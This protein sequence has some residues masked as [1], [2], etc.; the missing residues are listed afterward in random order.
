MHGLTILSL[1]LL[2]GVILPSQLTLATQS[3]SALQYVLSE[4]QDKRAVNTIGCIMNKLDIDLELLMLPWARAKRELNEGKVDGVFLTSP[5]EI[6]GGIS[7]SPIL[8]EKW[9]LFQR[10]SVVEQGAR[11][12]LGVVRG[13]DIENWLLDN[14]LLPLIK[15]R[16]TAQLVQQFEAGRID[17]FVADDSQVRF[18]FKAPVN[19]REFLRYVPK[20]LT[21]SAAVVQRFP[22]LQEQFNATIDKCDPQVRALSDSERQ[23]VKD[24][25]TEHLLHRFNGTLQPMIEQWLLRVKEASPD[26]L[27]KLEAQWQAELQGTSGAL[28]KHIVHN[29]LAQKLRDIQQELSVIAELML[30][31]Q[32]GELIAASVVTSDYWQGDELKVQALSYQP[33]YISSLH[34]DASTRQFLTH[35]SLALSANGQR[36]ILIV[37]V[38]LEQLLKQGSLRL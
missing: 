29:G 7:S 20:T 37:G 32:N 12:R 24:F 28:I 35:V 9:F 15:A 2:D 30:T 34:Y 27:K 8:L 6:A 4:E 11:D 23:Q 3:P 26:M 16:D 38:R 36:Y 17:Y 18:L 31:Q 1:L 25:I 13:S 5:D 33:L 14:Q 21:F 19:H 10:K 22:D